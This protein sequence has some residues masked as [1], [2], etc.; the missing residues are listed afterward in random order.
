MAYIV[1]VRMV[2]ILTEAWFANVYEALR[3]H[4]LSESKGEK[5]RNL[6]KTNADG[7]L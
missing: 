5:K 7:T 4:F 2:F 6:F 1:M 3:N